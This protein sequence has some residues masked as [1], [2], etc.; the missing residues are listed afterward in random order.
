MTKRTGTSENGRIIL[1]STG[2]EP[3]SARA[4]KRYYALWKFVDEYLDLQDIQVLI[5]KRKNDIKYESD[6]DKVTI[7][8]TEILLLEDAYKI[9]R[10]KKE[11]EI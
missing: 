11:E 2:E 4:N 5:T 9:K 6:N 8:R 10:N 7:L 1:T 3:K